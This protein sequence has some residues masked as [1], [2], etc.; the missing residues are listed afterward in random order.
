MPYSWFI[1]AILIYY[2]GF[3]WSARI[4]RNFKILIFLMFFFST[5]F[6]TVTYLL[7]YPSYWYISAYAMVTGIFIAA[8]ENRLFGEHPTSLLTLFAISI[9][10]SYISAEYSFQFKPLYFLYNIAI[11]LAFYSMVRIVGF[12]SGKLLDYLGKI[13]L[14]IYLLHGIAI[15]FISPLNL[16]SWMIIA[17]VI[18]STVIMAAISNTIL[19]Q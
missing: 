5:L 8:Y 4:A 6:V 17:S 11:C 10:I 15:Y 12:P 13:S 7:D 1:P 18:C 16:P 2:L 9:A 3:Y 19:S 14:E